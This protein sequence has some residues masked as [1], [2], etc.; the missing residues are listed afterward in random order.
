MPF[1]QCNSGSTSTYRLN[2]GA[3]IV[4]GAIGAGDGS[5]MQRLIVAN[6]DTTNVNSEILKKRYKTANKLIPQRWYER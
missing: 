6:V 5:G 2:L 1:G 3:G 4:G